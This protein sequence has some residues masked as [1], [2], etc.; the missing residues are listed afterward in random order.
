MTA[1]ENYTFRRYKMLKLI[2]F[3]PFNYRLTAIME[4]D[5]EVF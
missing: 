3:K 1:S 2:F 5:V 4:L